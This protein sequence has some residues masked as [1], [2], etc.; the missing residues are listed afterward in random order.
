M[1]K[2]KLF[3]YICLKKIINYFVFYS[4]NLNFVGFAKKAGKNMVQLQADSFVVTVL[5]LFAKLM[6]KG[7]Y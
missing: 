1:P 5:Q 6:K 4:V 3:K 2:R 7:D